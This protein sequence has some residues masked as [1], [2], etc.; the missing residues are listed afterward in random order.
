M[1]ALS[2]CWAVNRHARPLDLGG[3]GTVLSAAHAELHAQALALLR[4]PAAP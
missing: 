2:S 3:D 4:P 1:R